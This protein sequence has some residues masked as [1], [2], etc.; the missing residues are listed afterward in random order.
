MCV[1]ET[2]REN[3]DIFARI[4][5]A[6]NETELSIE[7]HL[8]LYI[9]RL[10]LHLKSLGGNTM[11][12]KGSWDKVQLFR[13]KKEKK[14]GEKEAVFS[15]SSLISIKLQIILRCESLKSK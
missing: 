7:I 8:G 3:L 11:F 6:I 2:E 12:N 10:S 1:Y 5:R 15:T 14:K 9:I 4:S 13:V